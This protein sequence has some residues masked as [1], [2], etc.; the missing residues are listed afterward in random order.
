MSICINK[1]VFCRVQVAKTGAVK[2]VANH[3]L[4]VLVTM[5]T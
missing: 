2:H 5:V 3:W 1:I 4:T